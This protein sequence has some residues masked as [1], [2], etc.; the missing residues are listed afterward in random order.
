MRHFSRFFLMLIFLISC[1]KETK[2]DIDT[3]GVQV[4][5]SIDRFEQLFYGY[6][7]TNLQGLK[8]KY[9]LMFPA[10]TPDSIWLAKVNDK[11]E[12]E[13]FGETEKRY[14][15]FSQVENDLTDLFKHIKYYYPKFEAPDVITVLSNI[16]YAYRVVYE[17]L[18]LFISIDVYLGED[19][20][21][22]ADYPDYIKINNKQER[23]A[24]DVANKIIDTQ[25][26]PSLNRSFL[27]KMIAAGKKLYLLD[28]Y[29]PL[30]SDELKIGYSKEKLNW[31]KDNEE[32]IWRYFIEKD[33]LY[34]TDTKLNKRFLEEA[35]FSKFYLGEDVNSPGRIGQWI[36]WQIVRS[37][38]DNNDVSLQTLLKMNED[39]IFQKSNY[40]PKK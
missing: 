15:D 33:L 27:G 35:P 24:V 34:S 1:Q 31:A 26:R 6:K 4:Q 10:N 28:L 3:S 2:K 13:L 5:Y 32:Q 12:K 25:V 11:D 14:K 16:D 9:P 19:H 21:F 20:P 17:G 40:K 36:G 29:I 23:I 18:L 22:Y 38:M 8:E 37:F 39:E 7:G 30:E